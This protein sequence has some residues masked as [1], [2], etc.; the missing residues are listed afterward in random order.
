[1]GL[2]PLDDE[3]QRKEHAV[4]GFERVVEDNDASVA[5][6]ALYD[7]EHLLRRIARIVVVGKYIPQI[8]G[9]SRLQH[10]FLLGIAHTPVRR[11]EETGLENLFAMQGIGDI[12]MVAGLM[13]AHVAIRM[14]AYAMSLRFD[15]CQQFGITLCVLRH[16]EEGSLGIVLAK[17]V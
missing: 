5:G 14:V 16:H 12:C 11:T 1:M 6:K 17:D 15:T 3:W 9:I 8:D 13:S 2:K 7:T 4:A 10:G